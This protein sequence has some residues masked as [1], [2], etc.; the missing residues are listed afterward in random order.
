M[1]LGGILEEKYVGGEEGN[2]EG[3]GRGTRAVSS[4]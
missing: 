2:H 1:R 4:L 3:G